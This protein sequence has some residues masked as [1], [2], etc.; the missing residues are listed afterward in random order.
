MR[1]KLTT[2]L[3]CAAA[4]AFAAPVAAAPTITEFPIPTPDSQPWDIVQGPDGN[5]WFI[6]KSVSKIGRVVPGPP[7][8]ITDYN[9]ADAG[10]QPEGIAVGPDGKVWYTEGTK[11][12]RFTPGNP[13]ASHQSFAGL[14]L[15]SG[16]GLAAGP[17]G[18][19]W[20]V[21]STGNQIVRVKPGDGTAAAPIPLDPGFGGRNI[22]PGSDGNMWATG[23][24]GQK[25]A[26]IT[27][28]GSVTYF[29]APQGNPWDI[30]AGPDGNLWYTA[31]GTHIGRSR[32]DGSITPFTSKGTDPFG[33][34]VGPDGALWYAEFAS[35]AIGRIDRSGTST[36]LGGLTAGA[37]PRFIASGPGRTLWFTEQVGNR[38][39]RITGIDLPQPPGGDKVA[40]VL[41]HLKLSA[42][43]FRLGSRLPSASAVGTGTT[44]RFE[45]SERATVTLS[46]AKASRGRRAGGRCVK[47]KRRNRARRRCTRYV[48]V[49]PKLSL[50]GQ[51]AGKRRIRFAGRLTRSKSLRPGAY[52]LTLTAR[53][54][55][56]NV[57]TPRRARFK[58]LPKRHARR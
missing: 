44:L 18:N 19:M 26:R 15:L 46:F 47:R 16:Q 51:Q 14:G 54:A 24:G 13:P 33:M 4:L 39:G 34:T 49:K 5:L 52:R 21:D 1:T 32:V 8:A 37:G 28:A 48:R 23:F 38:I 22:T 3:A 42:R 45:L 20:V 50:A 53:D 55:A 57:S 10:A 43:R 30:V 9:T 58:L 6:E 29:D 36:T 27:P 40:P 35:D 41:R 2:T 11:V 56:G 7:P 12:A 31:Q 17:D 25:I